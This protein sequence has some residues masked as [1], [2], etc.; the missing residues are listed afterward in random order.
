M[1]QRFMLPPFSPV[2]NTSAS[3]S[4]ISECR[5]A[6]ASH[7]SNPAVSIF[8]MLMLVGR[9]RETPCERCYRLKSRRIRSVYLRP[10]G[11][12]RIVES[13]HMVADQQNPFAPEPPSLELISRGTQTWGY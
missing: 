10:V 4:I 8:Q 5:S 6:R 7:C 1:F 2:V 11:V 13:P 9:T 3:L 12:A